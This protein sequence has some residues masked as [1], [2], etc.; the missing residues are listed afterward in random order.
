MCVARALSLSLCCSLAL[1][2]VLPLAHADSLALFQAFLPSLSFFLG[3][4]RARTHVAKHA[5]CT[6]FH[7]SLL[8]PGEYFLPS[9]C[10]LH[11]PAALSIPCR[12]PVWPRQVERHPSSKNQYDKHPSVHPHSGPKQP[13][14][15]LNSSEMS[16][17]PVVRSTRSMPRK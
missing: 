15:S 4:Q 1:S 14:A 2:R 8:S 12:S 6:A 10:A 11:L 5:H 16:L 9:S 13:R 3:I 17:K 7:A